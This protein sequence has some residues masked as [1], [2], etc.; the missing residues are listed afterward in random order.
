[1]IDYSRSGTRCRTVRQLLT[2]HGR[3]PR[4]SYG[5]LCYDMDNLGRHLVFVKWDN[6]TTIPVF[7][8]EIETLPIE[9]SEE[10]R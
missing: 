5:T 4:H 6:T 1:M 10:S 7:E 2:V 9:T 3:L 8:H